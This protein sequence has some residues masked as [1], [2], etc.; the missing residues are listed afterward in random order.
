MTLFVGGIHAVG[1]SFALKS[2]CEELGVKHFTASQLIEEQRGLANWLI[3]KE[4]TDIQ[5]NQLALITAVKQIN[6]TGEKVIL[7]GHFVLRREVD[8]H[9]KIGLD[10]FAQLMIQGV[11]LLEAPSKTIAER[12]IQRGD[13]TW[14]LEEIKTFSQLELE[15]A[16]AIC[17]QLKIPLIHLNLPTKNEIRDAIQMLMMGNNT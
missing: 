4:V 14:G 15:H 1:K 13:T 5:E 10:T 16:T 9:E 11:I 17:L 7:D 3:S 2:V 8:V 12:L 6:D